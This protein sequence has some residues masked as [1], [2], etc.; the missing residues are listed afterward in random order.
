MKI[1]IA[2]VI[3]LKIKEKQME[4]LKFFFV[5]DKRMIHKYLTLVKITYGTNVYG[6]CSA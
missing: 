6:K 4:D 2:C 1:V 5:S 3:K